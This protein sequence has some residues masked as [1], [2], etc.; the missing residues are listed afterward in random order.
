MERIVD[1][2]GEKFQRNER[3]LNNSLPGAGFYLC[4]SNNKARHAREDNNSIKCAFCRSRTAL[5]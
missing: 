2:L 1:I 5:I 3:D 4:L